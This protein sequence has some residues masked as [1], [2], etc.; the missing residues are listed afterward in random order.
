MFCEIL[1]KNK[2]GGENCFVSLQSH[3]AGRPRT[4]KG[5][6]II[7]IK[8]ENTLE[9]GV[10]GPT[11]KSISVSVAL[12]LRAC[13]RACVRSCVRARGAT[14]FHRVRLKN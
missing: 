4:G 10:C 9:V 3:G 8:I 14:G 7:V 6:Q 13:V 2:L 11:G 1:I 12:A 5:K